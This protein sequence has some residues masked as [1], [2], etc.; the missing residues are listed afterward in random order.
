MERFNRTV[1]DEFFRLAFRTTFY[2]SVA[3]LQADLDTWL[4]HYNTERTHQSYRN[5]GWRLM[6]SIKTRTLKEGP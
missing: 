1:L 5:M 3:A 6:P 4:L 2:E